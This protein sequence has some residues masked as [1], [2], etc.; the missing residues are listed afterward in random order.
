MPTGLAIA[1]ATLVVAAAQNAWPGPPQIPTRI[2]V[3]DLRQLPE[4]TRFER[5]TV[6]VRV[7]SDPETRGRGG[8]GGGM[9]EI[10]VTQPRTAPVVFLTQAIGLAVVASGT[11]WPSFEV[12][13]AAGGGIYTRAVYAWRPTERQ[14]CAPRVDEFEDTGDET[15]TPTTVRI[16]GEDRIVRFARS[17]AFGCETPL[18]H[19]GVH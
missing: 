8:S 13:S 17:R 10:V 16:A 7:P 3:V 15:E 5:S 1:A 9:L 11:S 6:E 14:Y 18:L 19:A 12:W 2:A 4:T